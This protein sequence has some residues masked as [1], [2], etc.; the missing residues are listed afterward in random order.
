MIN[1]K[2]RL[3]PSPGSLG[4]FSRRTI[5]RMERE[6]SRRGGHGR[7]CDRSQGKRGGRQL[8]SQNN[9]HGNE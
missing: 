6:S 2:R 7:G 8:T 3:S 4:K 5:T 1:T 9:Y